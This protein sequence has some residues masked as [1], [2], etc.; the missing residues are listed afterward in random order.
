[1]SLMLC[2]PYAYTQSWQLVWQDEFTNGIG[3]DWVFETGTGSGGWGNNELQYYRQQNASVS[4]GQLVITA[5]RENFGGMQYTSARMK[6]QGRKSWRYGRIEARIAIPAFQGVW[7]AFWMLGDNIT[8]VG[9]PACGEIDVMEHINTGG[10]VHGTM[11]WQDHNNNYANYGGSTSTNVT[12]F[13]VYSIEWTPNYIRWFVDG[14]QYHEADITNGINGTHEFHNNHF[15]ILNMAIGGNWPGFTVDNNAFPANMYVDYV[16]VYQQTSQPPS[17]V[18]VYQHCNYGGYGIGLPAGNYT[19]SDL[20]SRGIIND[21]ISSVRVQNGYQV[22][23]FQNNNFSGSSVLKTGDDACLVDDGFNDL[24][25][26]IQVSQ[27]TQSFSLTVQ[28]ENFSSMSGVQTEST[29]DAG[30]GLNV[31]WI[32]ANDWMAYGNIN[33]PATGSYLLEYRVASPGGGRL[34]QDLNSGSI[35]LGQ[36]NVPATGGWQNWTTISQTVNINAG[37]YSFGIFAAQGGWNINWWRISRVGTSAAMLPAAPEVLTSKPEDLL[38]DVYPNPGVDE[39][40]LRALE[41]D[42]HFTITDASGAVRF[43]GTVIDGKIDVTALPEGIYYISTMRD[44]KRVTKRF[45]KN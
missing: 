17:A 3:P 8:S 6:T 5:R 13:H 7:P 26:S 21:D 1:M 20:Q 42:D 44:G 25:T 40:H 39:I 9:W 36:V 2:S 41:P 38:F 10:N 18:T 19:L 22:R 27:V 32:D 45:V 29:S 24:T 14:V 15:I 28:A 33:V 34:S 11:H 37:T 12:A 35:V 30:G 16:R 43:I 23:L 31:G 4:N